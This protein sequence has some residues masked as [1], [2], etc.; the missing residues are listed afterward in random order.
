MLNICIDIA[1]DRLDKNEQDLLEGIPSNI[2]HYITELN[3]NAKECENKI[4]CINGKIEYAEKVIEQ[5]IPEP[6]KFDK[7]VELS[8]AKQELAFLNS[9]QDIIDKEKQKKC[10]EKLEQEI[11]DKETEIAELTKK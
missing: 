2:P 8:L 1:Y 9:N 6:K 11:L 5:K 4:S 7:D 10:V 3:D